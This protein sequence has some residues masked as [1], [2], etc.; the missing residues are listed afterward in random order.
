MCSP[1]MP[2]QQDPVNPDPVIRGEEDGTRSTKKADAA[3]VQ[4]MYGAKSMNKTGGMGLPGIVSTA[5][6]TAFGA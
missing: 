5:G 2:E 4:E 1:D 3:R 6:K